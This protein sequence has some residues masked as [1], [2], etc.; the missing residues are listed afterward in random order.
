MTSLAYLSVSVRSVARVNQAILLQQQ[1]HGCHAAS[2][3]A[4]SAIQFQAGGDCS[5]CGGRDVYLRLQPLYLGPLTTVCK[6]SSDRSELVY[7]RC[8]NIGLMNFGVFVLCFHRKR[9]R[10]RKII[11]GQKRKW[12]KPSKISIFGTKNENEIRSDS[13]TFKNFCNLAIEITV[14]F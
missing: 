9:N 4:S 3:H 11:F 13:R 12:P 8:L 10:K 7:D 14:Y 2:K 1:Q 5:G 6:Q